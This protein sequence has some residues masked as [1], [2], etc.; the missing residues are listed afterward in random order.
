MITV[1]QKWAPPALLGRLTGLLVLSSFG[2]FPVSVLLG[3]VV[4]RNLG[5]A[6]FFPMAAGALALAILAGLTQKEWRR[7]GA[8]APA[9]DPQPGAGIT[10]RNAAEPAPGG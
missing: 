2:I 6:P 8:A 7:L 1:F 3:A 9:G 10:A 5:P 4:V